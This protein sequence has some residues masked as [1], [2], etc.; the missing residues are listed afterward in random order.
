MRRPARAVALLACFMG[1]C[2]DVPEAGPAARAQARLAA[3]SSANLAVA[4]PTLQDRRSGVTLHSCAELLDALHADQDLGEIPELPP[5]AA[6][7]ECIRHAVVSGS[8]GYPDVPFDLARAGDQI[9][10][11]LDLAGVPS[12][13]AQR[14]P[15]P[16][17]RLQDFS[18]E[19]VVARPMSLALQGGG[20]AY[21]FDV[22]AV[23]DFR[24]TGQAELL[25]RF[26]ERSTASGTYDRTTLLV[27]D[28]APPSA[29]ITATSALDVLRP[30]V[31]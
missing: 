14:R 27:L 2:T 10:R 22:L 16:H 23:G 26:T 11:D 3:P 19:T 15:S 13:L 18:F 8:V 20:F 31:R 28:L 29:T 24:H 12:S 5:F 4:L 1:A 17:Y 7:A 9:Y 21:R 6:Y 30:A 25:V